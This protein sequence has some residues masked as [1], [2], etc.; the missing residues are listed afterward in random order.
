MSCTKTSEVFKGGISLKEKLKVQLQA[1][2][3]K[4]TVA[5]IEQKCEFAKEQGYGAIEVPQWFVSYAKEKL[6]GSK[7]MVSTCVGLPGGESSTFAKYAEV[8]QAV[9]NKADEVS[10]P[11]NMSFINEKKISE[12]K[13]DFNEVMSMAKGKSKIK[14]IL[15]FG[16][17]DTILMKDSLNMLLELNVDTVVLSSVVTGKSID[18]K[19]VSKVK[20]QIKM[21]ELMILGCILSENDAEEYI[22]SGADRVALS[23]V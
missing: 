11:V 8:K 14:A 13:N 23:R 21:T 16:L 9:A 17:V 3:P 19:Y 18:K 5:G 15:E 10:I 12:A 6:L 4:A 1:M 2:D 22:N 20:N 7:V